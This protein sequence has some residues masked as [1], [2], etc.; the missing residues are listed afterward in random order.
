MI[1][2]VERWAGEMAQPL[3]ARLATKNIR[4]LNI[5][6]GASQPFSTSQMRIL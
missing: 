2:D 1:K 6:L 4:M 5:S 3:K